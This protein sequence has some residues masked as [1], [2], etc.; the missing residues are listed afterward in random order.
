MSPQGHS[1]REEKPNRELDRD[2]DQHGIFSGLTS[3]GLRVRARGPI[4]EILGRVP[5]ST[6][7]RRACV[8]VDLRA[9]HCSVRMKIPHTGPRSH[10]L[11]LELSSFAGFCFRVRFGSY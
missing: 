7:F 6:P 9:Q 8:P 4:R 3:E 2:D 11:Q 5:P 10:S 1:P